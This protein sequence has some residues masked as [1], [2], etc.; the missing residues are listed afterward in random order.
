M[1]ISTSISKKRALKAFK[2][3][4][5]NLMFYKD[6]EN[7][8]LN[9]EDVFSNKKR[10]KNKNS[11]WFKSPE[12]VEDSFRWLIAVG[13]LRREVDG[14]GLTCK[15]RLTPLAR[16]LLESNPDIPNQKASLYEQLKEWTYKKWAI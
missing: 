2:C 6:V 13:I 9:A 7:T 8:G 3:A 16:K 5:F 14:Q 1:E 10:Y 15:V 11:K 12:S 4:Y